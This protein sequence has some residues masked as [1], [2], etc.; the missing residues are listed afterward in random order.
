PEAPS[1]SPAVSVVLTTFNRSALVLPA[2]NSVLEQTLG[3]F[4]L[5]VVDDCSTD[6]TADVVGGIR[7][8][9]VSLVRHETNLGLA[10]AR[11]SRLSRPRGRSLCFPDDAEEG[12][13]EKLAVQRAA[14]EAAAGRAEV[15]VYSQARVDD[16]FSSDGRPQRGPKPREP[17]SE[18]LM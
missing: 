6:D 18:Y 3:D 11:N 4:E 17:M 10:D 1:G 12:R 16:G 5:I 7:D 9:R 14:F 2:I 15:L 8:P 13:T